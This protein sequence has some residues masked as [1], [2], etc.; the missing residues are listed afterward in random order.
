M[1]DITTGTLYNYIGGF[2]S[3]IRPKVAKL[4]AS[5]VAIVYQGASNYVCAVVCEVSGGTTTPGT[6][7]NNI[8]NSSAVDDVAITRLTDTT[9]AVAYKITSTG[10]VGGFVGVYNPGT[11]AITRGNI[12]SG[13]SASGVTAY[14]TSIS[15]LTDTTFVLAYSGVNQYVDAVVCTYN[16]GTTD[17]AVGTIKTNISNS[18]SI[19]QLSISSMTDARFAVAYCKTSGTY[20]K[21]VVCEVAGGI[22]SA[23][24]NSSD[25]LTINP[26]AIAITELSPTTF[27]VATKGSTLQALVFTY[28]TGTTAVSYGTVKT[29]IGPN[30]T[31]AC[32]AAISKISSSAFV[33]AY[34]EGSGYAS[35]IICTV[36]GGVIT[37]GTNKPYI[38]GNINDMN[39]LYETVTVMSPTSFFAAFRA[40]SSY[41]DGIACSFPSFGYSKK[42]NGVTPAKVNGVVPTKIN[43]I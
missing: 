24:T 18:S 12:N 36:A 31:T 15:R 37:T 38:S 11:K 34:Q 19:N 43:G 16:T 7:Y 10:R 26:T 6:V 13:L 42:I 1:Y 29:G 39:V 14:Y 35:A 30:A 27:V 5:T 32:Y 9:F 28:D 8:S 17:I 23:G 3:V 41:L 40:N 33:I 20:L 2:V 25:L 4:T 22:I 21:V